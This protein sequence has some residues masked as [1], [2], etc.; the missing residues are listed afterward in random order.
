MTFHDR[1]RLIARRLAVAVAAIAPAT[2]AAAGTLEL[3]LPGTVETQSVRYDCGQD[4]HL[5][6]TYHNAADNAL[7]VL[8]F[9]GRTL[10]MANV[11]AASG[12]RY[13][14]GTHV[15]WTKGDSGDLYDLTKGEDAPPLSCTEREE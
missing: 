7:A 14:G 8:N 6:A 12:A 9:E 15:W 4:K 11:L 10:V 13:A 1:S 3:D 2:G 5:T